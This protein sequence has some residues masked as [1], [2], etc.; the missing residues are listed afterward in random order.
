L[1]IFNGRGRCGACHPIGKEFSLF[2][3]GLF[4]NTGVGTD[5]RGEPPDLGRYNVTRM[6]A[7]KGAFK[8]PT[9]RSITQT[10]PYMH[11]GTL[12]SLTEV[13]EFY[14]AGGRRNPYLSK[15]IRPLN[16][17]AQDKID[18]IAF[19]ESLTGEPMPHIGPPEGEQ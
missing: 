9:L 15:L 18:L 5:A 4:H 7:D 16:F 6:E 1:E 12:T 2:T 14:N 13:V 3:D 19:L 10:R 11:D 17:S 8:T